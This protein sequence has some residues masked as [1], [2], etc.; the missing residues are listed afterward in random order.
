MVTS[1]STGL[2]GL[3]AASAAID[4]TTPSLLLI[5]L[6]PRMP[7][8]IRLPRKTY[9]R[10]DSD[11]DR[12]ADESETRAVRRPKRKA[13]KHVQTKGLNA[14]HWLRRM[15]ETQGRQEGNHEYRSLGRGDLVGD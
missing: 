13:K 12:E 3:I 15:L 9:S 1:A 11:I 7:M 6:L 8:S 10:R 14:F 5:L 4:P 2:Q